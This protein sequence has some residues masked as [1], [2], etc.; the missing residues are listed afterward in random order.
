MSLLE[1]Q[2][3]EAMMDI[4][5]RAKSECGYTPSIFFNMLTKLRGV[6]TAKRLINASKVSDGYTALFELERLDLTVEAVIHD[7]PKWH[8]LFTE[9]ELAICKNRLT[10]YHYFRS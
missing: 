1:I 5:R 7:Q 8:E 3:D 6:Q 2:F 9:E 4:Y 10:Q